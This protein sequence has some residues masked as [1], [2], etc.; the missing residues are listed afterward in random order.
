MRTLSGL[1]CFPLVTNIQSGIL[2]NILIE[3]DYHSNS[4]K[5]WHIFV[6]Y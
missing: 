4:G 6:T 2:I 3:P 5:S 1:D